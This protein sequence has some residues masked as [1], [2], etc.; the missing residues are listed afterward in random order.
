MSEDGNTA[1]PVADPAAEVKAMG[2]L[3]EAVAGLDPAAVARV[4]RWAADA[5]GVSINAATHKGG[6]AARAA[7]SA[8]ESTGS[9][10]GNS[11][12]PQFADIADLFHAAA[13]QAEQDKALVGAYWFQFCEGR[14][15]FGAQEVNSALNNLG[16]RIKNITSAFDNLKARKPSYVVQLK[17]SGTSKQAR[18]TYKLTVA[19]KQAVELMMGPH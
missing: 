1:A 9:G 14:G 2:K 12:V 3:A 10:N 4:L 13:P 7:G 6:T 15:E 18:K 11:E 8:A 5:F 19:G 17:K 16:E